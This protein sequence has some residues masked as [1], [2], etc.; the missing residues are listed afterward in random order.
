[1]WYTTTELIYDLHRLDHLGTTHTI[2]IFFLVKKKKDCRPAFRSCQI[3][4]CFAAV[5]L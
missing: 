1:M 4:L 2:I 3:S 5:Y